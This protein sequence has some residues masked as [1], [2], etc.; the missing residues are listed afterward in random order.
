MENTKLPPLMEYFSN[1]EDP[2]RETKNKKYPLIEVIVI[3]FLAVM[4]GADGWESIERYGLMRKKWLGKFLALK[5]GISKHD[6]YRRVLCAIHSEL[7]ETCFMNWVRDIKQDIKR[8]VIAI[9][10]KTVRG[11]ARKSR[12][13]AGT[14]AKSIHLVSAWATENQLVFA[15]VQTEEKSNEITAIPVLLEQIAIEGCIVTID[16]MGCQYEIADKIV[17]KEADYVISLKGNQENLHTVVEEYWGMLDFDKPAA[18]AKYIKFRTVST[19]DEKH[20]RKETRDYAVSDDVQWLREQFPKW[21]SINSIGVVES[22]RDTG[23]EA[24]TER[25][26]FVSSLGADEKEFA[27]AVR[28]HWWIENRLHYM[29]DV[30]YREDACRVRKDYSPRTLALIRKVALTIARSD[31]KS[32][33]SVRGRVQQMAWSEDYLESLLFRSDFVSVQEAS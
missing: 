27:H 9:D 5:E 7:L 4:S 18:Q 13:K 29:L 32:K 26:Y 23:K 30:I 15:Q 19:Y 12:F 33:T 20:G 10:G 21:K 17:E 16:A 11:M 22:T 25:R 8:E 31:K 1:I 14:E 6:V 28:A 24:K 3:A 2:R